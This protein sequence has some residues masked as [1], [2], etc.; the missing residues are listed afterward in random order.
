MQKIRWS[1]ESVEHLGNRVGCG[2]LPAGAGPETHG[3][4]VAGGA[5]RA[6]GVVDLRTGGGGVWVGA[7]E[8]VA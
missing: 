5:E 8:W 2:V 4:G 3:I 6:R 1:V 7:D